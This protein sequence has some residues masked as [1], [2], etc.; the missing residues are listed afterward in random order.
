MIII[1][2]E[3]AIIVLLIIALSYL[4]IYYKNTPESPPPPTVTP[5][6]PS[7]PTITSVVTKIKSDGSTIAETVP[8]T[9][10]PLLPNVSNGQYVTDTE[11]GAIYYVQNGMLSYIASPEILIRMS[12]YQGT[13][14]KFP[15][16]S[17]AKMAFGPPILR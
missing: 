8:A 14:I 5:S 4:Y 11:S 17:I 7:C 1:L 10:P 2:V 6:C 13:A 15:M 9:L 3:S 12:D 16:E